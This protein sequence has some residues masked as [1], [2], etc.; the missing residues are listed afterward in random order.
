M[1]RAKDADSKA[2]VKAWYASGL[3]ARIS[4]L[5]PT[6]ILEVVARAEAIARGARAVA[7]SVPPP[8]TRDWP[9]LSVVSPEAPDPDMAARFLAAVKRQAQDPE[10]DMAGG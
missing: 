10:R 9:A 7:A 2:K 4:G 1:A 8:V 6:T 5:H 3:A